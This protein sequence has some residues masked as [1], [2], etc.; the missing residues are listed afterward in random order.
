M[1]EGTA[2]VA[3][4]ARSAMSKRTRNE[5]QTAVVARQCPIC[6]SEMGA[7]TQIRPFQCSHA[8]C[9]SCDTHMRR[10]SDHRCP[11]CRAPRRGMSR[12]DAEPPPDR[13][14]GDPV[15]EALYDSSALAELGQLAELAS[16]IARVSRM[17]H[18]AGRYFRRPGRGGRTAPPATRTR[19]Q[20]GHIIVFP[21]SPPV[22]LAEPRAAEP[23]LPE[24]LLAA[25]LSDAQARTL[26]ALQVVP[27]EALHGLLNVPDVSIAQFRLRVQGRRGG[28]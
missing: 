22:E 11:E 9:N 25:G 21:A 18:V 15:L 3:S 14:H 2:R 16:E 19:P 28:S 6:Y 7:R 1:H 4:T 24:G 27:S 13:N 17:S 8:L 20:T 5:R 23:R 10:V 26:I 12:E